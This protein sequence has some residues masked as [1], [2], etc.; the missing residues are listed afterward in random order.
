MPDKKDEFIDKPITRI[1][2]I[3]VL[4]ISRDR[5][6]QNYHAYEDLRRRTEDELLTLQDT[7]SIVDKAIEELSSARL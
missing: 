2:V 1:G 5:L 3:K 6:R 4:Q 7:L